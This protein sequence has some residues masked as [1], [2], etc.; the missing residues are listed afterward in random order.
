[1]HVICKASRK[2]GKAQQQSQALGWLASWLFV[3]RC[4]PG[5]NNVASTLQRS[6]LRVLFLRLLRLN[7][8]RSRGEYRS[9]NNLT[10]YTWHSDRNLMITAIA[11]VLPCITVLLVIKPRTIPAPVDLMLPPEYFAINAMPCHANP[12]L[13]P[14]DYYPC[15]RLHFK[16][17]PL[18]FYLR[19]CG[20]P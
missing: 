20:L 2:S 10:F 6:K 17:F 15:H 7:I 4:L 5:T 1:M 14:R 3:L 12:I 9:G 13:I 18:S 11:V 19:H 8:Q 16:S